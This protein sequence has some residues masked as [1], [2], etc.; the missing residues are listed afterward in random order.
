MCK[1]NSLLFIRKIEWRF[2]CFRGPAT[3]HP[4]TSL[5]SGCLKRFF[6]L[7]NACVFSNLNYLKSQLTPVPIT[8]SKHIYNSI[9]YKFFPVFHSWVIEIWDNWDNWDF[10]RSIKRIPPC[11]TLILKSKCIFQ[12]SGQKNVPLPRPD[13]W[14]SPALTLP[15]QCQG[16]DN[17]KGWR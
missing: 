7:L 17:V 11:N 1:N 10:E 4:K 15:L 5:W 8:S 16:R 2:S 12:K 6:V 14:L 3:L 9:L 13:F